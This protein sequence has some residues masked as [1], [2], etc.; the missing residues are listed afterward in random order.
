MRRVR[1]IDHDG[2]NFR[3]ESYMH[4]PDLREAYECG[5]KEG[6]RQAME[7]TYGGYGHRDYGRGGVGT[8]PMDFRHHPDRQWRDEDIDP[9]MERRGRDSR[10][11]YM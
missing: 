7:E 10:G 9:Y 2:M 11:R 1:I 6:W 5:V 4:D 8:H 3:H